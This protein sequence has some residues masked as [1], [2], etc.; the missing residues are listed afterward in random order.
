M[1]EYSSFIIEGDP[2]VAWVAL[3]DDGAV[4]EASVRVRP[5]IDLGED[6]ENDFNPVIKVKEGP[7]T[8]GASTFRMTVPSESVPT[9][10]ERRDLILGAVGSVVVEADYI[11]N[12]TGMWT[13]FDEPAAHVQTLPAM[14]AVLKSPVAPEA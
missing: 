2:H 8:R 9:N 14:E 3:H 12:G 6:Q 5:P 10:D 1:G 4:L 7:S 11:E 13:V